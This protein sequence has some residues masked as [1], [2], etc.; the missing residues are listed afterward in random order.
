MK[1]WDT[2]YD[3][4]KYFQQS[5]TRE[6]TFYWLAAVLVG[7]TVKNDFF[8]VTSLARGVGLLPNYYTCMLNFFHSGSVDSAK[9]LSIWIQ[10]ILSNFNGLVKLNDRY[11]I[12]ADGIKV[13]KEGK[14]MPGVKWLH[15]D[16][17]SNSKAEYIMGHSIQAISILVKGVKNFF[18][19]P[20]TA[21]IHEGVRFDCKDSRTL[22][23]KL[24]ELLIEMNFPAAFYLIA[25][26]YYCSGRLMKQLVAKN[27]HLIT[28]MKKNAVAYYALKENHIGRGRP[29]KY[30]QSVKL[31]NLFESN[32]DFLKTPMPN[33][34]KIMIEYFAINLLWR[35]LGDFVQFVLVKHPHRGNSIVM[36]TDLTINP[37]DLVLAYSLR[38]KIEVLFKQAVHQIGTFAYRFWLKTMTPR[39]RGKASNDYLVH[40]APRYFKEKIKSKIDAYHLFIQLGF[41]AQGL[42]QYLS[43]YCYKQVWGSFGTWLRTIR[44]HTLPSEKVVSTAL[45]KTYI[46][47]LIDNEKTCSFKKFVLKRTQIKVPY[48]NHEREKKAA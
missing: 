13:G 12:V 25:D 10:L 8:G 22:L 15:Q 48:E 26:K 24:F 27:I 19:V 43:L 32:L 20:L 4:V 9:V 1:L 34:P 40:F 3:L 21:K 47:F 42:A 31:F 16:S 6:K 45:S 5:C 14:K 35:P 2:W 29:K 41:I 39:K 7:F 23:D 44:D 38:F 11:L 28:M 30:G 17:E 37:L 33:N 46:Q 36:S 18:A